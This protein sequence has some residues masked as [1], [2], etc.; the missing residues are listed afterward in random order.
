M[1]A[2]PTAVRPGQQAPC[3]R[4]CSSSSSC[5]TAVFTLMKRGGWYTCTLQLRSSGAHRG[6]LDVPDSVARLLL[7]KAPPVWLHAGI[8]SGS[9]A[10]YLSTA[11]LPSQVSMNVCWQAH[12]LPASLTCTDMQP[13][14][15]TTCADCQASHVTQC[16]AEAHLSAACQGGQVRLLHMQPCRGITWADCQA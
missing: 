9:E 15:G 12:G 11:K 14:R 13:C 8:R 10:L 6:R 5:S 3:C 4:R 16:T 1:R 7:P 2:S